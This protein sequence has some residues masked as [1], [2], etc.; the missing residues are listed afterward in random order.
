MERR[1]FIKLGLWTIPSMYLFPD[2]LLGRGMKATSSSGRPGKQNTRLPDIYSGRIDGCNLL[3]PEEF[4]SILSVKKVHVV[5]P[6]KEDIMVLISGDDTQNRL[7]NGI[8]EFNR[9]NTEGLFCH[10]GLADISQ[11]GKVVIPEKIKKVSD[12]GMGKVSVVHPDKK[13]FIPTDDAGRFG[14]EIDA[15]FPGDISYYI[16]NFDFFI[17]GPA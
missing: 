11:D 5:A 3:L 2:K 17:I 14:F 16:D 6:E 10:A 12:I 8:E 7:L 9:N 1:K 15:G 4:R 13:D